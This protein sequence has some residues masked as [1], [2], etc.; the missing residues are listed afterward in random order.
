MANLDKQTLL[1]TFA[2]DLNAYGEYNVSE[3]GGYLERALA[4]AVSD[5]WKAKEWPFVVSSVVITTTSGTLGPYAMPADFAGLLQQEEVNRYYA[6]P[7]YSYPPNV[8]VGDNG[9][10][11]EITLDRVSNSVY[12]AGN[13]GD[14][15]YTVN[16]RLVEP[17]TL[18]LQ[19]IPIPDQ[20]WSRECLFCKTAF[21]ALRN[22]PEQA[23]VAASYLQQYKL[24]LDTEWATLRRGHTRPVG[25]TPMNIY[26]NPFYGDMV[27]R[28]N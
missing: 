20:A 26:G 16:Y 7:T 23:Q 15:T 17:E 4:R 11:Y 18:D 24:A 19:T 10:R 27:G 22:E 28:D 5:L 9:E 25:R 3:A 14:G 1:N 2:E 13:P 8:N 12:F 21:Y 6:I